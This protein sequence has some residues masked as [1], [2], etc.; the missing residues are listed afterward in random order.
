[1]R[2]YKLTP[3]TLEKRVKISEE[4]RNFFQKEGKYVT[5]LNVCK[6]LGYPRSTLT[7]M[8]FHT[9]EIALEFGFERPGKKPKGDIE[10]NQKI[11]DRYLEQYKT[12]IKIRQ[13]PVTLDNFSKHL[14]L[15][16]ASIT[17]FYRYKWNLK[18]IH[19][20]CGIEYHTNKKMCSKSA[21]ENKL[22]ELIKEKQRYVVR[23]ELA[24]ALGVSGSL[25]NVHKIDFES[26]NKEFG[27]IG[28]NKSFESLIGDVLREM[29]SGYVFERQKWF[30][31]CPTLTSGKRGRLRYDYYCE[32]LNLLV[33]ADG[34]A[35]YNERDW[36][37][38]ESL[39]K[40][41]A[42]KTEYAETANITLIRIPYTVNYNVDK[43]KQ[44]LSGIPLKLSTGQPAAKPEEIQEGSTTSRK[45]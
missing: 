45:T 30:E 19:E 5:M 26:I 8:G 2:Q 14:G 18:L 9:D 7:S 25:M 27:F 37:H 6:A 10:H 43:I 12:L 23:D 29:F 42:V 21:A 39:V 38:S 44:Y 13:R 24:A 1:M 34:P 4:V 40:R 35:H 20:E 11:T 33:E 32:T 16:N 3:A 36:R 15:E 31:D 17:R 41:D 22:R 28:L